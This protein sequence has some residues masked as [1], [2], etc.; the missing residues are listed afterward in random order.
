MFF[1]IVNC[2]IHIANQITDYQEKTYIR[3]FC[4]IKSL[5][6]QKNHYLCH[7]NRSKKHTRLLSCYVKARETA[8]LL[9]IGKDSER[10]E[11]ANLFVF[12]IRIHPIL[13]KDSDKFLIIYNTLKNQ[14]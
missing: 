4:N 3:Y 14:Q 1:K 13:H 11:K 10:K 6:I 9:I 2:Y 12:F 5:T 7:K 8:K